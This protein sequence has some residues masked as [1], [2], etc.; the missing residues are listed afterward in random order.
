M[1]DAT[2]NDAAGKGASD[3]RPTG[4]MALLERLRESGNERA[5][6]ENLAE[7]FEMKPEALRR[8]IGKDQP[9]AAKHLEAARLWESNLQADIERREAE[10]GN[11]PAVTAVANEPAEPADRREEPSGG[12]GKANM[13]KA[14]GEPPGEAQAAADDDEWERRRSQHAPARLKGDDLDA[15]MVERFDAA[16]ERLERATPRPAALATGLI[17]AVDGVLRLRRELR[18]ADDAEPPTRL[19]ELLIRGDVH[20]LVADPNVGKSTLAFLRGC[21]SPIRTPRSWGDEDRL[22]RPTLVVSNEDDPANVRPDGGN[23]VSIPD[24]PDA[25]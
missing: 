14:A 13:E 22:V 11:G 17:A 10:D 25:A 8:L 20:L 1:L 18:G 4:L 3:P 7:K 24:C 19:T 12:E 6:I 2:N 23:S 16:L 5:T 21:Q 15:A 9:F